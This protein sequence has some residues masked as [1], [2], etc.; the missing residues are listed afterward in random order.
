MM[1]N[2]INLDEMEDETDG[3]KEAHTSAY[4]AGMPIHYHQEA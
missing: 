3:M 1:V 2:E 4:K